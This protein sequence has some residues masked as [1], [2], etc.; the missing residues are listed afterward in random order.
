MFLGSKINRVGLPVTA[1]AGGIAG[2]PAKAGIMPNKPPWHKEK[3]R[4]F[5]G[6]KR[7]VR[8]LESS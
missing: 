1:V 7:P 4:E 8:G 2:G 6:S 3:S 5:Q